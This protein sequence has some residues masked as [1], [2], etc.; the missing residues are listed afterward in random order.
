M[1]K[2]YDLYLRKHREN[3]KKGWDWLCENLPEITEKTVNL[4]RMIDFHDFSK[5][6]SEE[7]HAYDVYF[8]GKNR[9]YNVTRN[10]NYAWLHHIH[11]NGHHWQHWVLF[12]DDPNNGMVALEMPYDDIVE[13]IC[14]WWSFSWGNGKLDEIFKWYDEHKDYIKLAQETRRIVEDILSQIKKKLEKEERK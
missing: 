3:V 5:E 13:M 12:N 8:Y 9:S 4:S 14:D 1:S 11:E 7:Y 6:D 10:F 2:E